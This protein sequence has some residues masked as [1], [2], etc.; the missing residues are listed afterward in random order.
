MNIK[1]VFQVQGVALASS[2][3]FVIKDAYF[4][5]TYNYYFFYIFLFNFEQL[6]NS[7]F[8]F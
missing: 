2:L 3:D 1:A 6:K 7:Y 5:A 8:S 4:T